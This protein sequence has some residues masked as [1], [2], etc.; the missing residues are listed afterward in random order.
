MCGIAGA[1]FPEE[2]R[3]TKIN[4]AFLVTLMLAGEQHR[5]HDGAGIVTSKQGEKDFGKFKGVGLVFD[6]LTLDRMQRIYGDTA[7]G[8]VRYSTTGEI[9]ID[10]IQPFTSVIGDGANMERLTLC[11][12]GNLTSELKGLRPTDS[13]SWEILHNFDG[14]NS[15]ISL[16]ARIYQALKNVRGAF[17][18]G[19]LHKS[20]DG[21]TSMICVRDPHGIRPLWLA[22]YR[23]GFGKRKIGYLF[24]S[25]TCAFEMLSSYIEVL[26]LESEHRVEILRPVR[27]GEIVIINHDGLQSF[28]PQ[29]WRNQERK[30][31]IF[32]VI[33]Y[34]NPE[35][36][37]ETGDWKKN[38]IYAWEIQ[39]ALGRKLA[40][41]NPGLTADFVTAVPDS[42]N[43]HT[44]GFSRAS[45]V[46]F[47]LGILRK[48]TAG[49]TFIAPYRLAK[50]LNGKD[51]DE[52]ILKIM[53]KLSFVVKKFQQAEKVLVIDDSLVRSNTFKCII[54]MIRRIKQSLKI[55]GGICSPPI[56]F[57]CFYGIATPTKKELGWNRYNGL[58]GLCESIS[59]DMLTYLTLAGLLS[60]A[61]QLTGYGEDD[62]C[63]ACFDGH[64][65][66]PI[67]R[68]E[69]KNE[70]K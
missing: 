63:A 16:N 51:L 64:Y 1:W 57:P 54:K 70:L 2:I 6:V 29:V 68:E 3:E 44:L 31:C 13:D 67:E 21:E 4:P 52:R 15:H 41:E 62:W 53:R 5:G 61:H 58:D 37:V 46:L 26:G 48:H 55:I 28:K 42:A 49:R 12:N 38:P 8:H 40:E 69:Q 59:V 36:I 14:V 56:K 7:I 24:A 22:R 66:V 33:Y 43:H 60:V 18:L 10:N 65:P 35:S 30:F 47:E 25:E 17:S 32:E 50:M 19:M 34:M 45:S 9:D 39:E 23:F 11:H 27:A 20:A